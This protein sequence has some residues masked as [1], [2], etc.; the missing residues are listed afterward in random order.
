MSTENPLLG[1]WVTG[2]NGDPSA[3]IR[4][5]GVLGSPAVA[6]LL[7][8]PNGRDDLAFGDT[9]GTG[10]MGVVRAAEQV[11]LGRT[12]AVKSLRPDVTGPDATHKLLAEAWVTGTLEHPNIVPVYDIAVDPDHQPHIVMKRIAGIEWE[13]VMDDE[14]AVAER[15]G[16]HDLLV[17]N[18]QI[19]IQ[20][21]NAVHFAHSRGVVHL[22]LKPQNVMIGE[23]GEVYVVDWGIAVAL[24]KD[25]SG[26]IPH[27]SSARVAGTPRYMAP[28]MVLGRALSTATDVYLLGGLLHR[29]LTGLAP[30][31]GW[32]IREILDAVPSFRPDFEASV[33]GELAELVLQSTALDPEQRVPSAEQFRAQINTFL[34]HRGSRRIADVAT[35]RLAELQAELTGRADRQSIY[36]HLGACRF[37]FREALNSWPE[38]PEARDG[39][40][41]ALAG[42]FEYELK[43]R[44]PRAATL[45]FNELSERTVD[46]QSRL[47]ALRA[48][49][50]RDERAAISLFADID[51]RIGQRT[52]VSVVASLGVFWVLSPLASWY[53]ERQSTF[54]SQIVMAASI[55]TL[56]GAGLL[57]GRRSFL[58]TPINRATA[59]LVM[60][61]PMAMA[62]IHAAFFVRGGDIRTATAIELYV[63]GLLAVCGMLTVDR[64][65]LP[66][67]TGF[68]LGAAVVATTEIDMNLMFSATS[69]VLLLTVLA[70]WLP[71]M[72]QAPTHRPDEVG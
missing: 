54:L 45:L 68:C 24:E 63:Y 6:E 26:R 8:Q 9:I 44:D 47:D 36:G 20:V 16:T 40:D 4:P 67:A 13:S 72:P 66:V 43:A 22:D 65:L 18:L 27:S 31:R 17:W 52:R 42:V 25:V 11:R 46:Q 7:S 50:D 48:Q 35:A 23:F 29:I 2:Y 51:P 15:F 64:R 32:T 53:F 41:T 60:L 12:V 19:L 28:E 39:L 55:A 58:S 10:G 62:G 49:V 33:P 34:E 57:W 69:L 38:N 70:M 5:N 14:N 37:G 30:H 59:T 3:T 1:T 61:A 56:V 21:C 71:T